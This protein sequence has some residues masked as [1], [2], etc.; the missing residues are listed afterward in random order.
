MRKLVPVLLLLALVMSLLP[1]TLLAQDT[2]DQG[3]GTPDPA[4]GPH[5]Y[6]PVVNGSTQSSPAVDS[7]APTP[8]PD[9]DWPGDLGWGNQKHGKVTPA[10]RMA[11]AQRAAAVGAQPA[12]VT[13]AT[14][15]IAAAA[16]GGGSPHFFGPFPNYAN[17]PLPTVGPGSITGGIRKFVDGLPG[18]GPDAK[19]NL[20]QYIPVAV[21]DTT[22]YPGSD[23]YEIAVVEYLEK[24]HTDLPP[25]KL[26]GYV[27]LATAVVPGSQVPLTTTTGSPI[28]LP[29]GTQAIG[30]DGPHY[31]G[32]Q[33]FAT[34]DKPVRILFR[35]LLPTGQGGNLFIPVDVSEM[36]SGMGPGMNG[37]MEMD[38][39]NP[40]CGMIP[41]PMGCYTENRATVHLHGGLTPWISDGTAHQWITP[42]GEDTMYPKGVSVQNVPDM[43]D[44]GPGAMTFFYT[45]QQSARLL[46]YHDH[47]WG[48]TRLNVYAGEAAGYL[49]T[50]DAEKKLI[51]D[52]VV[53]AEQIPLIIQD[54]TFVPPMEQRMLEDPLWDAARWGD[55]GSLWVPHVYMPAQN[56][57]DS[58]G[59]NQFGRW[60]YG[61]WFWPPTADIMYGPKANPHYDPACNPDLTWCEPPLIPAV[62]NLSMGMEAFNDTPLGQRH[63]LPGVDRRSQDLPLPYP[64]CGGRPLLQPIA[65]QGRSDFKYRSHA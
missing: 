8:A 10:E 57:G 37:M 3:A 29:D 51:A 30:V 5:V 16:M 39:Q 7:P 53:P 2:P 28:L 22:T 19:N 12:T 1:G 45:N 40:M 46:F 43:P 31:L 48:I 21:P 58:S 25:T 27:Q 47:S 34:K 65:V 42:A 38:P 60:A 55:T 32:P 11:A 4:S 13:G 23:Y 56:P 18:L 35:N 50:D 59:V 14:A 17:S 44:P 20:G 24:M 62:P 33:I 63:C 64:E 41:K 6:L 49:I 36:G 54:K 26:R 52:Q 15:E 61:P 9:A